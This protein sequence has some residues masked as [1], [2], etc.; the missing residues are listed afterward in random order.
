[1]AGYRL[2]SILLSAALISACG[3]GYDS[4][5][6][7]GFKL[8]NSRHLIVLNGSSTDVMQTLAKIRHTRSLSELSA[9]TN[10]REYQNTG[11]LALNISADEAMQLEKSGIA[12]T[13][14]H[15]KVMHKSLTQIKPPS[16]GIDRI[17]G[18]SH[19]LD[20]KY[21]YPESS[22]KGVRAFIIDTGI[23]AKHPEFQ[24]RVLPG[25]SVVEDTNGT[26]DCDG[27][28]S[29]VA[30]TVGGIFSG[31]AKKVELVPVRVLDC[32][33][34]GSGEGVVA[35]LDWIIEQKKAN[36]TMAMVANMSL[37]GEGLDALDAAAA[38]LV[39]AGIFVAVAAGNETQ[40]ACNVSPAR[41][42]EVVT[43]GASDS[44]D[45]P[46]YFSN[47]GKCLDLYAPGDEIYSA[48]SG[49]KDGT[50]MSG[51]S[52]ASPHVAG[53][54]ALIL[55]LHPNYTPAQVE[56]RIKELALK[57]ILRG[58]ED[59]NLLLQV[60]PG[61]D[62]PDPGQPPPPFPGLIFRY[63]GE[64]EEG[65]YKTFWPNTGVLDGKIKISATL[66]QSNKRAYFTYSLFR[67]DDANG[68][69]VKVASS[70]RDSSKPME[71]SGE[72]GTFYLQV[73]AISG[74]SA[75]EVEMRAIEVGKALQ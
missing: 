42:P 3:V 20:K 70:P 12:R 18:S 31:V 16:W 49:S 51:T 28:G 8:G 7:L 22:G 63:D 72:N 53:A 61:E 54:G 56:A 32:E 5:T 37:G 48:K 52:M 50:V 33:G 60:E 35:G 30:G 66:T 17:D 67:H 6:F 11:I 73:N 36:P 43:V 38:K 40:D 25:L 46:A 1:M 14:E 2:S 74:A 47:F 24:G 55:G 29:H 27:H 19:G 75:F 57:D 69:F 71:W 9:T 64:L 10:F 15:D 21:V 23:D 34:S 39:Q 13:I 45:F 68:R 58:V 4:A 26:N 44:N 41:T 65:D 62:K 59:A